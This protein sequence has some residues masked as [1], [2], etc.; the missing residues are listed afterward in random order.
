[1]LKTILLCL[2]TVA[3]ATAGTL[4]YTDTTVGGPTWNR[5]FAG[6]PPIV[7]SGVGTAVPY[8]VL[9]FTVDLGGSYIFSSQGVTPTNWDN[10]TFLYVTSFSAASPL[11]N[12]VTGNDD[13]PS[14][15]LSGFTS[16][17]VAGTN[18]FFVTTGFSNTNAGAFSNSITGPGSII[19]DIPEPSSV[20]LLSGGLALVA[21]RARRRKSSAGR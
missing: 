20:L 7:L 8:S 21:W 14:I 6:T 16:T 15:G 10:Y 11:T 12:A 19:S 1:M 3:F 5:P 13:N 17:L 9:Q 4:N 18:Y 2:S